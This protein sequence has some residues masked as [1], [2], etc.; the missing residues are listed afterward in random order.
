MADG[1]WIIIEAG[2]GQVSGLSE[3]QDYEA[4]FR[5]LYICFKED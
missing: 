4:F 5:S 2:D 1:S 3:G